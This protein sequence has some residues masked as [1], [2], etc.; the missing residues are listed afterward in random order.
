VADV[1]TDLAGLPAPGPV[2]G[3]VA[4]EA[5]NEANR[6][7]SKGTSAMIAGRM[8]E[9]VKGAGFAGPGGNKPLSNWAEINTKAAQ[10]SLDIRAETWKGFNDKHRVVG[11][12]NQGWLNDFGAL[13]T[14]MLQMSPK[15]YIDSIVK[16]LPGGGEA[17]EA[18]S[19]S[20]T[21][22][23]LGIGSVSGLTPFN[24]LAPS[25]LIYPVLV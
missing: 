10:A 4:A 25:R 5:A 1:L 24:L 2:T 14:A 20:W 15:D 8:P 18:V 13:K 23:N 12:L 17:L 3:T 22:G 11:E 9:L 7:F 6:Y 21:A 16:Y 19:K